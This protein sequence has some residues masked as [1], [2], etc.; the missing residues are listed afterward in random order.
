MVTKEQLQA[1]QWGEVLHYGECKRIQGPRG[2]VTVQQEV[3]RPFG[4][5]Q[6]WKTRPEEFRLP[7]KYG[8]YSYGD[9]T[10][11]SAHAFHL[12]SNCPLHHENGE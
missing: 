7:L 12:A 3:W 5:L 4:K 11:R 2:G 9:V 10:H 1:L 8:L 6:T